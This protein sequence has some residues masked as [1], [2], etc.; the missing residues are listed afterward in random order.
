[1]I[2]SAKSNP[3]KTLHK[4]QN[5]ELTIRKPTRKPKTAVLVPPF[6]EY[7]KPLKACSLHGRTLETAL[8]SILVSLRY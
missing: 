4:S 7:L 3:N 8:V 6:R 2:E 5:P 1:M